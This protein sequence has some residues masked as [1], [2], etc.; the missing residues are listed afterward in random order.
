MGLDIV[1]IVMELE[2]TFGIAFPDSEAE[3]LVS[4]GDTFEYVVARL[5]ARAP[6]GGGCS[7][8]ATFYR[9]RREMVH[10]LEVP[11]WRVRLDSRI[12]DLVPLGERR[13][14]W[15]AVAATV[16]LQVPPGKFRLFSAAPRFPD[17]RS[18][19]G[20][21]VRRASQSAFYTA[22]GAVDRD[23]VW[24]K[25]VAIVSEASGVP[26]EKIQPASQYVNDL[27]LD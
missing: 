6:R 14:Q 8:A 24:R 1:E 13:S 9:L 4:V 15:P 23:A 10:R 7:T 19:V 25:V 2:D 5:A 26:A 20:E 3:R 17:P 16:G 27:R 21:I 22:T 18:T 11:R 12:G